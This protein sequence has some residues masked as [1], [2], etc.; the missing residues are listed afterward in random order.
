M[1]P[2]LVSHMVNIVLMITTFTFWTFIAFFIDLLMAIMF[3]LLAGLMLGLSIVMWK[4]VFYFSSMLRETQ[5]HFHN[6][7]EGRRSHA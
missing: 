7:K 6:L 2:W 5:E 1:I 4:E 3:P